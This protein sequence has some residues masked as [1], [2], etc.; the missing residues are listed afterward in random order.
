MICLIVALEYLLIILIIHKSA[1]EKRCGFD[2]INVVTKSESKIN[3]WL[4]TILALCL[5]ASTSSKYL[6]AINFSLLSLNALKGL[7]IRISEKQSISV[8]S[9]G[10]RLFSKLNDL[11]SSML[12][13]VGMLLY[14]S[15]QALFSLSSGS[16]TNK[17]FK[18][19]LVF[20]FNVTL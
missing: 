3:V 5:N 6:S 13:L 15:L 11:L 20:L 1:F 12:T 9:K 16:L 8:A 19:M 4:R 10:L 7:V 2:I 18:E 14:L 17:S